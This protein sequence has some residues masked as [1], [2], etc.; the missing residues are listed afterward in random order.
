M[1]HHHH[2]R[3][4]SDALT[5]SF[6]ACALSNGAFIASFCFQVRVK[7]VT[8]NEA[9]RVTETPFAVPTRLNRQGLSQVVNH[10]LNTTTPKPFDF[11]IDDLFLRSSLEKY[12]QQHSVSEE[13]LLT[14][15]YVEALPQPEK[16]NETNHPDW[17]S[18]VAVAKDVVVTGCYDGQVR[19]YDLDGECNASLKSHHGAIKSVSVQFH[20]QHEYYIATSGKDQMGQLWLYN[21]STK[22][23]TAVAAFTGHLNSVDAVALRTSGEQAITGS[24]DN[25]VRVW[26]TLGKDDPA[27]EAQ[28]K[29][30]QKSSS[31][32][33]SAVTFRQLEAEIVLVGHTS[34]ITGVAFHPQHDH[35]VVSG[36]SDRSVRLWDLTTHSCVQTLTGNRAITGISVNADGLVLSAHPDRCVRLWDPRATQS[37][38][39]LVQRTF[40]SHK[41]W[42]SAVQWHPTNANLFASSSYD[43][44]VKIWDSRS[45]IPLH[46]VAAHDGKALDVAWR[47][48]A[49]PQVAF[50]SGGE[51]KQLKFFSV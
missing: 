20:K 39:N 14:L 23:I 21:A 38:E 30:K 34:Y 44:T 49:E 50:V 26:N 19:V 43:G 27:A 41:E 4:V 36:S 7:F 31:S 46:T 47:P 40:N 6:S 2:Y 51:D 32:G 11:L 16:K 45:T 42:V 37:G 13:S 22:Q 17:V 28:P 35:Q 8:K 5:V 3:A 25:T 15:E 24:W 29:K 33:A 18:A 10:L 9:I 12:M 48:E 1:H